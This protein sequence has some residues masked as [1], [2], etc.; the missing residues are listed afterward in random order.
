MTTY[1]TVE[2]VLRLAAR[3]I[4]GEVLLRDPGLLDA[5]VNRPR[6]S[7]FGEDVYPDVFS[8]A[9]A[10]LHSIVTSH[11]FVDGNKRVGWVSARVFCALNGHAGHAYTEDDAFE[12][13]ITVATGKLDDVGEIARTL[14]TFFRS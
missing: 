13:V 9:A 8:K 14:E 4:A 10:M 6:A 3:A 1:L 5:A 12:F 7:V 2:R 11:P